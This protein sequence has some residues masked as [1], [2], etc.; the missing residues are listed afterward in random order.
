MRTGSLPYGHRKLLELGRVVLLGAKVLL[1]DEP[2]AG[3]NESEIEHL[4]QLVLELRSEGGLSIL[5]VEHNM[6][7]VRRLCDSAVV[8]DAGQVIAEG[9]PE[10]C[11]PIRACC[12]R[13]S[14][15]CP[16]ML[17]VDAPHG[18]LRPDPRPRRRVAERRTRT[19][20][21]H[22]RRQRRRQDHPAAHDHRTR[23]RE[24]RWHPA[25]RQGHR[26]DQ[27]R[28]DRAARHR[29]RARRPRHLSR[30]LGAREL[31]GRGAHASSRSEIAGRHRPHAGDVSVARPAREAGRLDA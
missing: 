30:P 7:L 18:R 6:G 25:R 29:S 28:R 14:A 9:T 15:R 23:A 3:L 1:L 21:R 12:S 17:E 8:L 20:R 31:A 22:P 2:I 27:A 26:R 5:L 16:P 10:Q 4:G 13:I 24:D 19:A 11:S